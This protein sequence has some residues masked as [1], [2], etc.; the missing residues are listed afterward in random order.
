MSLKDSWVK[1]AETAGL[2]P[3]EGLLWYVTF[4]AMVMT[5]VMVFT[6][7]LHWLWPVVFFVM[8]MVEAYV[9]GNKLEKEGEE[10][11]D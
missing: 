7:G 4:I 1:A 6:A 10:K 9:M 3:V 5:L 2:D 8:L 11:S